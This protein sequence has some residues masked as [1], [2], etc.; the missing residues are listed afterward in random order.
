M[1]V[2]KK[3]KLAHTAQ[4]DPIVSDLE[5]S[6][7]EASQQSHD[8][9]LT[10][11]N[12]QD[13]ESPQVQREEAVTKSFKDLGIIDSL[14]EACEA[15]GYKSPT[16]IQAESIPLALQG[17]DLIGLAE[18]GSGKTAAFALPILQA[19]MNKPQSLFGLILAPTRELAC[20]ISEA[21]EALGS[22]ISVR[23][24]VIVGGMDMVSQAISLGKKPHIIVATPGRLLDHLE[25]T[26]GFSLRSLKYLVMDEADRLLDLDFG[27]ILDKILKVLPRERRTY[28]F[29][30][31]MS[32]KV[33]SLQRASLS[34]PLRVS[35]SSNKYQTV[36]TLLQSYL[37]IPHKY[38]DIYLVYLLNEYAGQSAIVFTR[39]VNETQRLAILLRALG[40]GSIPLHGQLS[41]SSRLGALS[42]F[43]SRSRDIL[44]ATD[45]AAR[46]L[47]IPSVDVVLNFDLPSDSKTYIHRVGRTARAGKSGHAFSIVTQYDIEVW[48]RIENALGKKLDEYKV[49]KEEVMVL[50][51]R[52][53]EA[54]R[55]AITEMKDLHEKRGSRGATLKGRRPAKGAK[56]GRDEMD[57]EE[58]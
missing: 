48:L 19:L 12:E 4:P 42:K 3:R 22:L 8:E 5:S 14:C 20:Q 40:F 11:A 32:S 10:A 56:R 25:N 7:S 1:P 37:F 29:S 41:Q 39:T 15:L 27:P 46:G 33:E 17:R 55:H 51:D 44:V 16:P 31:T 54:Q 47:D 35:I 58:G 34:N 24:A 49:E 36:A 28:L 30:A 9:Q 6:S 45:V 23:C 18:T 21:F 53:G 52:V 13:D 38:K 26:K 57:R 50:S 43:R 2:L